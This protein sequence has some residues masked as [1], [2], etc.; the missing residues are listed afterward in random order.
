MAK[1]FHDFIWQ[2]KYLT[3]SVWDCKVFEPCTTETLLVTH[4]KVVWGD[5]REREVV[6]VVDW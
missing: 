2:K 4:N 1:S 3:K 5:R 6:G